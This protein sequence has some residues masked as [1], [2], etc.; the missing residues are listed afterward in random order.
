MNIAIYGA[1]LATLVVVIHEGRPVAGLWCILLG[2]GIILNALHQ[3][4]KG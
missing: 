2:C 3:K 1:I 4:L